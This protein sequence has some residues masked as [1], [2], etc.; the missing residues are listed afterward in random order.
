MIWLWK[1]KIMKTS[2][3]P[4]SFDCVIWPDVCCAITAW[5]DKTKAKTVI[6]Y[7]FFLLDFYPDH[8]QKIRPLKT[9]N[10]KLFNYLF[11]LILLYLFKLAGSIC[12][13]NVNAFVLRSGV[14]P[15]NRFTSSSTLVEKNTCT[16]NE[17]GRDLWIF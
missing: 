11:A 6:K 12:L 5:A 8:P 15:P 16:L 14:A 10:C 1:K 3:L 9:V 7:N 13:S 4:A 2:W 17:P